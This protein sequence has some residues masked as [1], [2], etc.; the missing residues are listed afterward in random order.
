MGTF[1]GDAL[2][3]DK[4][5]MAPRFAVE[6]DGT[7][8]ATFSECSGLS[9][10]VKTDSWEEGGL[11]YATQKFP[12]RTDYGNLTLKHGITDSLDLYNWFLQVVQGA[13]SRKSITIKLFTPDTQKVIRSWHL[14]RAFPVKWTGPSLQAGSNALAI[15]TLEFAHDGLA[16]T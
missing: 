12:G 13:M 4:F 16:L 11:N 3:S 8:V 2:R 15:E 6:A 5:G 7:I 9:A 1:A 10:T 14:V